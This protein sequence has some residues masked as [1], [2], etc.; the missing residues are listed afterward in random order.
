L[1]LA[2]ALFLS[3]FSGANGNE[4]PR[5]KI[6]G[7]AALKS[8]MTESSLKYRFLSISEPTLLVSGNANN[9]TNAGFVYVNSNNT[10]SNTNTNIGSR[11]SLLKILTVGK[12]LASWQKTN[13]EKRVLVT[14]VKALLDSSK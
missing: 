12:D 4:T 13:N 14:S 1:A 3:L 6:E 2:F 7:G 8:E 9:G 10:P 5:P 11:L